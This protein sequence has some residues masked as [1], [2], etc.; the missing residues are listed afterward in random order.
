[1]PP[2]EP[3]LSRAIDSL[4]I[5]LAD[6]SVAN[7][8]WT[9]IGSAVEDELEG[10]ERHG[11]ADAGV[12]LG[13]E[14]VSGADAAETTLERVGLVLTAWHH[15]RR[16]IAVGQPTPRQLVARIAAD[17]ERA[18]KIDYTR[19]GLAADTVMLGWSPTPDP[20]DRGIVWVEFRV[21]LVL[22]RAWSDPSAALDAPGDLA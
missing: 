1:M 3:L 11:S 17:L 15:Y 21:Q 7:G 2:S 14:S 19:G 18:A 16:P 6:I 5:A 8:Y 4:R 12:V 9:E 20:E 22:L 10:L 13:I